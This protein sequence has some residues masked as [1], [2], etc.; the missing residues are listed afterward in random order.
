MHKYLPHTKTD[1]KEML[2]VI[3]ASSLDA[4]L[5][6]I[7][8]NLRMKKGYEIPGGLSDI[9]LTDHMQK[10][11]SKN[12]SFIIFRGY[13]AYDHYTPSIVKSL[14]SRQEFLTSYT[15]YQPEVSQGTLQY[16]FEYQ[17]MICEITGMDVTNASMY[18]G[19]TAAAEAMFMALATSP[20]KRFVVS[21]TTHP[22]LLEVLKTYGRFRDVEFI[23]LEEKDGITDLSSL[24]VL[25]DTA[26]ILLQSPNK[27]GIIEDYESVSVF[28]KKYDAT[29]IMHV[30]IQS[31]AL[32]K[33]PADYG[34]DITTGDLQSLGVPLSFGGAYIGFLAAKNQLLRQMPG[35][36]CGVTTDQVGKRAFVLTLQARE[37]HIRRAKANSNICSN[38]SLMALSVAI[39]LS[40][41][42]KKGFVDVA[43]LCLDGAHYLYQQLLKT[44]H[45]KETFKQPFF[46]EFVL[47]SMIDAKAFDA[48]LLSKGYLGPV[49]LE[50]NQFLFTVTEKR[51]KQEIDAFIEVVGNFK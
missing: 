39:Y 49:Y 5:S 8:M 14:T 31:L 23:E 20:F 44:N 19:P 38:Q 32:L 25:R 42:G 35:R 11:A 22:R 21:K 3:G 34:A 12:K 46:K 48:Y 41:M 15:P 4:L 10:L 7:P 37:Q 45:F 28:T 24:D 18:D 29:F 40:T 1:I 17:S 33:R 9:E 26:G 43:Q 13:G 2:E 30:D 27:Y 6:P 36:I 51:S 47:T 16:I 50:N